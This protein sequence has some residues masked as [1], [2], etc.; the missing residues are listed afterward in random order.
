MVFFPVGKEK[1]SVA[2]M[3]S[4]LFTQSPLSCHSPLLAQFKKMVHFNKNVQFRF[5]LT[6]SQDNRSYVFASTRYVKTWFFKLISSFY[7]SHTHCKDNG[8]EMFSL[9]TTQPFVQEYTHIVPNSVFIY[10]Y[11]VQRV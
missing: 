10:I 9:C 8:S 3:F 6:Y 11:I 5:I 7:L 4:V 1:T 2:L